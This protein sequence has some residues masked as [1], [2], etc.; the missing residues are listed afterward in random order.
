[1]GLTFKLATITKYSDP[2]RYQEALHQAG[3]CIAAY[4]VG[5]GM[6]QRGII[7]RD[8]AYDACVNGVAYTK[9]VG[10]RCKGS[11]RR[12]F[13][14][15]QWI[16]TCFAGPIAEKLPPRNDD[17]EKIEWA[18]KELVPSYPM[19]EAEAGYYPYWN[20]LYAIAFTLVSSTTRAGALESLHNYCRSEIAAGQQKPVIDQSIFDLLWPL[21]RRAHGIIDL[22]WSSVEMLATDLY[23]NWR[24]DRDQIE[25]LLPWAGGL[26]IS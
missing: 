12:E 10:L 23:K 11:Q 15:K 1:M 6:M 2:E 7:L 22:R 21:A 16:V 13:F 26:T 19:A 5:V 4:D 14:L 25:L 17:V 8:N 3:H 24:L 9:K 18:V 20:G